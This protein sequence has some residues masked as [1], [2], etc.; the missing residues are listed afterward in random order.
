MISHKY[1][2]FYIMSFEWP[3]SSS[4]SKPNW[5]THL[6]YSVSIFLFFLLKFRAQFLAFSP[7]FCPVYCFYWYISKEQMRA[8]LYIGSRMK[9]KRS[10][11]FA[12]W[13]QA[14]SLPSSHPMHRHVSPSCLLT[15]PSYPVSQMCQVYLASSGILT[16]FC[17]RQENSSLSLLIAEIL[18]S[19]QDTPWLLTPL[20]SHLALPDLEQNVFVVKSP[21]KIDY[22]FRQSRELYFLAL[23]A[24][25]PK[26]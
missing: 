7:L 4:S 8:A 1:F 13:I 15:I 16:E 5:S 19:F 18:F 6:F 14:L 22:M 9:S 26:Y 23:R 25:A 12:I 11:P 21:L 20:Y 3:L 17:P 24:E 10:S 2:Y